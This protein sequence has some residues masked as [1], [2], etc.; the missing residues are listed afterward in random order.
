[1]SIGTLNK[2][3]E[4]NSVLLDRFKKFINE[5]DNIDEIRKIDDA[6][7]RSIVGDDLRNQ[8]LVYVEKKEEEI[9]NK[10]R[11]ISQKLLDPICNNQDLKNMIEEVRSESSD[12]ISVIIRQDNKNRD[13]GKRMDIAFIKKY[14]IRLIEVKRTI[15]E[16]FLKNGFLISNLMVVLNSISK[17]DS[18]GKDNVS[19]KI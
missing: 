3:Q 15:E 11:I 12:V 9:L 17:E 10:Y 4:K 14:I 19:A 1:M 16:V 2:I 5:T 13:N 6:I 8:L 18:L 7:R